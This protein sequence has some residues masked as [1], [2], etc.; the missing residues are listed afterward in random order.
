MEGNM[1]DPPLSKGIFGKD[2]IV[3]G[4][5]KEKALPSSKEGREEC[6]QKTTA[7]LKPTPDL[8]LGEYF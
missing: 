7:G 3:P 5:G 1:R 6:Q 4:Q 2:A 8:K